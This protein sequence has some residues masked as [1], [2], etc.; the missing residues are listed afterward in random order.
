MFGLLLAYTDLSG[1]TAMVQSTGAPPRVAR[2]LAR[3]CAPLQRAA[4][5]FA[6]ANTRHDAGALVAATHT[7][8]QAQPALV[9]AALLVAK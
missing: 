6:Q 9:K 8:A 7:A 5:L 2:V 3:P 1:C 4:A